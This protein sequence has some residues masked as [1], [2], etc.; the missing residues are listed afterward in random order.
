[1]IANAGLM[2]LERRVW[3]GKAYGGGK[4]GCRLKALQ[5]TLEPKRRAPFAIQACNRQG[6]WGR[7]RVPAAAYPTD[8]HERAYAQNGS[9]LQ[10]EERRTSNTF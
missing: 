6:G 10:N 7:A 3:D 5:V 9:P 2:V 1:M 8:A 4:A